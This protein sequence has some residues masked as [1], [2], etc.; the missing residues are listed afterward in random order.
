MATLHALSHSPFS[1]TRL[2]SCLKLLGSQ[3]GLL[4]TGDAVY[5]LASGTEPQRLLEEQVARDKLFVL[6]E[7]LIARNLVAPSG[8]ETLGYAGFVELTLRFDRVNTWL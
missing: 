2:T 6:E 3:D 1:D 4:L 7:D 5:A 8:V